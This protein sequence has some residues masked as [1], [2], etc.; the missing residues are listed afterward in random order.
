MSKKVKASKYNICLPVGDKD[1]HWLIFNG[2][3][4]SFCLAN[5]GLGK[6]LDWANSH[7][8][9]LPPMDEGTY[10]FLMSRGLLDYEDQEDFIITDIC[11]QEHCRNCEHI[12]M[13]IVPSYQCNFS[14]PYCFEK[15]I[16]ETQ[17]ER[18]K[19]VMT[20][21]MVDAIFAQMDA[22]YKEGKKT[23]HFLFFGGEPFLP[24]NKE[25]VAHTCAKCDE[26]NI[27]MSVITNGYYLNEY[28]DLI[29]KYNFSA[30]KITIDGP[31][32]VHDARRSPATTLES[33]DRIIENT[34]MVL[35]TGKTV[36]YRTNVNQ[37]NHWVIT[38][39]KEEYEALGLTRYPNFSYYFCATMRSFEQEGNIYSNVDIMDKIGN[40]CKNYKYNSAYARIYRRLLPFMKGEGYMELKPEFCVA[41]SGKYTVDPFGNVFT[42]WDLMHKPEAIVAKVDLPS[43]KFIYND[44]FSTWNCRTVDTIPQCKDCKYMLFCGGG[45]AAQALETY[46]DMQKAYCDT[47]PEIFNQVALQIAREYLIK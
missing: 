45:C 1:S 2:G 7:E 16:R 15:V 36:T 19:A 6:M 42:C 29:E 9:E 26:R 34:L 10:N 23:E 27:P 46:G 30:V 33:F 3:K 5:E 25:V 28:I 31:K 37:D 47:F 43:K 14:C 35:E 38:K 39:M 44:N 21:E 17:H 18:L 24:G 11:K 12:I 20:C 13:S 4:G 8:R 22:F 40:V 32:E 41:H